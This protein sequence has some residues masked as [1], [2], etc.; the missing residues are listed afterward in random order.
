MSILVKTI[1]DRRFVAD[2]A[3]TR[4]VALYNHANKTVAHHPIAF[5]CNPY[6]ETRAR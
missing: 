2:S 5:S 4:L 3:I 6:T 1:G